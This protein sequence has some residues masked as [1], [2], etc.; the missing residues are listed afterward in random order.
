MFRALGDFEGGEGYIDL[1][2]REPER[3]SSM[4]TGKAASRVAGITLSSSAVLIG[5]D[6]SGPLAL[7]LCLGPNVKPPDAPAHG[8]ASDNWRI[9]VLGNLPMG[10]DS[11]DAGEFRFQQ[12]RR[13]YASDNYANGPEGGWSALLFADRRGMRVRHVHHEGPAIRPADMA[14]AEWLGVGGDLVSEDP[15]DEPGAQVMATTI[16]P[17]RRGPR[18]NG[19]FAETD[20]WTNFEGVKV[21]AGALG[22]E[23]AGPIVLLTKVSAGGRPFGGV[24]LDTD[25]FRLVIAGSYALDGRDYVA[26][27]MRVQGA[28]VGVGN[29]VAGPDGVDEVVV[30][31]DRRAIGAVEASPPDTNGWPRLLATVAAD[32]ATRVAAR[33]V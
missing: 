3:W 27:D 8:H 4:N 2:F 30:I 28:N 21:A 25:V 10:P 22:D 16:D 20:Q 14:L 26:G 31:A 11:Y 6:T 5:D 19:S 33:A 29:A 7:L 12:G 24:V 15:A 17:E 13:P 23:D 18:V 1:S 32:L 9:S